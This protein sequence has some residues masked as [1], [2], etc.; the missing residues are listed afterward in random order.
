MA[1]HATPPVHGTFQNYMTHLASFCFK[2]EKI[3]L[4]EGALIEPLS[5]AVHACERSN[6]GPGSH[7]LI[8]GAGPIGI[9]CIKVARACGATNIVVTDID[10]NRLEFAK[11]VG[12]D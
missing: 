3:S 11:K 8:T 10:Q 9:V 12:A 6:V 7:C 4:D 2:L 5:V 1:F